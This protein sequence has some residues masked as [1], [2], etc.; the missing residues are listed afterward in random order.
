MLAVP[1]ANAQPV[2]LPCGPP[3]D[4]RAGDSFVHFDE[5]AGIEGCGPVDNSRRAK[6]SMTTQREPENEKDDCEIFAL[7]GR[8]IFGWGKVEPDISQ[9]AVFYRPQGSGFVEQCPWADLGVTPLKAAKP[10]PDNMRFFTAPKYNTDGN[11]ATVSFVTK[12]VARNPDGSARPPFISQEAL[13][14]A[15]IEGHW[16]LVSRTPGPIT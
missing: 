4:I 5:V 16:R 1:A 7:L 10:N 14:L 3:A 2:A 12:L 13:S 9:F 11:S 15:K 8:E 6:L